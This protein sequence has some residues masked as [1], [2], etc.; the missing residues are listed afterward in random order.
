MMQLSA[1]LVDRPRCW[2][3]NLLVCPTPGFLKA[4]ADLGVTPP[5]VF[6][7]VHF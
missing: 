2:G 3:W 1:F 4:F 6:F 7:G 5:D